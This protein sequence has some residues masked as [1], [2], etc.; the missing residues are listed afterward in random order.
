M[1]I[2]KNNS[3]N[4]IYNRRTFNSFFTTY[5]ICYYIA[6]YYVYN[7]SIIICCL[8]SPF[9]RSFARKITAN[10][11]SFLS[12]NLAAGYD[13]DF[14]CCDFSIAWYSLAHVLPH[15]TRT[16]AQPRSLHDVK[17]GAMTRCDKFWQI[18]TRPLGAPCVYVAIA[19]IQIPCQTSITSR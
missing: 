11:L 3:C 4:Y 16:H 17:L 1:T 2:L 19:V 8:L 9:H 7:C 14:G 18:F 10:K 15:S 12:K 13:N 5:F 6:I